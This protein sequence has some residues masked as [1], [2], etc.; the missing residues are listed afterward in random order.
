MSETFQ[1]ELEPLAKYDRA[2]LNHAIEKVETRGVLPSDVAD[3]VTSGKTVEDYPVH[4]AGPC[5]LVPQAG[6]NGRL[7]HALRGLKTGTD[8]PAFLMT[9]Y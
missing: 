2:A 8:R 1:R 7:I 9:A 6:C 4:H 5:G 3:C